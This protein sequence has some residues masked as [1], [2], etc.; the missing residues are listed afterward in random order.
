[1]IPLK[2]NFTYLILNDEGQINSKSDSKLSCEESGGYVLDTRVLSQYEWDLAGFQLLHTKYIGSRCIKQYFSKFENHKQSLMIVRTLTVK[3]GG[4]EDE[5]ELVNDDLEAHQFAAELKLD[6]DFIDMFEVRGHV[7]NDGVRDVHQ[8]QSS[9]HYDAHYIAEDDVKTEVVLELEGFRF[10]EHIHVEPRSKTILKVS[11]KFTSSYTIASTIQDVPENWLSH[12]EVFDPTKVYRQAERDLHDLLLATEHGLTI[13]AGIPWFV[14][15]FGR[16][17]IIASWFLI[18]AYPELAKGTLQYLAANQ[19]TK[20]DEYRDEQPGKILHEQRYAEFSRLAKLPFLT[21][22][23]TADATPLFVVL[24]HAYATATDDYH[25]VDALKVNWQSALQWME[26][27]QDDRGLIVFRGNTQGLTVQSWKDSHDS[28]SYRNGDLG[29]GALAVAEVQGYAFA[30]YLA[31][32]DF[33]AH[34]GNNEKAAHYTLQAERLR[35]SFDRLFWME[36]HNNFAIAVDENNVQL[37]VNSSDSGHLLWSG[38]VLDKKVDVL[39][40]RLF[41][42]DM[43]SGWGLRTLST[44]EVRYN[45]ISYHNGSVWPHDTAIF[46][47]G[48]KRYGKEL[49]FERVKQALIDVASSQKDRRLPELFSG[50]PRET[51]PILPYVEACRP[52]AWSAAALVYLMNDGE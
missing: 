18:N 44:K 11:A 12:T 42:D 23:G 20:V 16:D 35:E 43:W 37:D 1:M 30:A 29:E 46:A 52:Q 26:K 39:V 19:G 13:A 36:E 25:L 48:L 49:Q 28:L 7:P 22:Y 31:A 9:S 3:D 50:Y 2:K 24:L 8:H 47:A 17:S 4:F 51:T 10:H 45:P 33:Y 5:L 34:A 41:E 14:T 6:S 40:N 21:Y 15:P 27:Y 38:I 32:A